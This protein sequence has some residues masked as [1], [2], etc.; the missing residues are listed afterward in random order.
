[1]HAPSTRFSEE[2]SLLE[3]HGFRG[4]LRRLLHLPGHRRSRLILFSDTVR[5]AADAHGLGR[6]L[7]FGQSAVLGHGALL[8]L[9]VEA[10]LNCTEQ[11]GDNQFNQN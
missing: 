8:V 6:C 3:L 2:Q 1:M 5:C 9:I 4:A 10:P 7:F 11:C